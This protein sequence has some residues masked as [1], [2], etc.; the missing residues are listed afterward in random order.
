MK[1]I[2][3]L[4]LFL[5]FAVFALTLN[6]QNPDSVTLNYYFGLQAEVDLYVVLLVP[7]VIGLLLGVLIM[8]VSVLRNKMEVGK[9]RRRLT[10]VEKEVENLRAAPISEPNQTD[11]ALP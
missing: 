10:K 3:S 6:L 8:S 11:V 9:T 2:L 5:L 4:I 7:F 1:K